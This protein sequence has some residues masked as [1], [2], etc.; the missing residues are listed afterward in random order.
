MASFKVI[1]KQGAPIQTDVILHP[2][3]VLAMEVETITFVCHLAAPDF[4]SL[5]F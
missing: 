3:E 5:I 1:D 2:G 4:S